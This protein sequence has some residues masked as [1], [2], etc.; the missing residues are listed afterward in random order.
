MSARRDL[1]SHNEFRDKIEAV[2]RADLRRQIELAEKE[3][4][5]DKEDLYNIYWI[6]P[7]EIADAVIDTLVEHMGPVF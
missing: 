5:A 1:W 2:I 7:D 4:L 6:Y 3:E